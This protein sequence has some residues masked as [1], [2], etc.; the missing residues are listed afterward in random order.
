MKEIREDATKFV[1]SLDRG[2]IHENHR[3]T[4]SR[5]TLDSHKFVYEA[6]NEIKHLVE[7]RSL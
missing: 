3:G 5:L 2:E 7:G 6:I 4:N 1:L